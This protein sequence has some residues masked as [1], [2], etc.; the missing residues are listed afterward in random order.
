[1]IGL[2]HF[3]RTDREPIW[4]YDYRLIEL[5]APLSSAAA[6]TNCELASARSF[7]AQVANWN[8]AAG[9]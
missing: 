8:I 6:Y 1:M 9:C 7:D 4:V 2:L 3:L 5:A